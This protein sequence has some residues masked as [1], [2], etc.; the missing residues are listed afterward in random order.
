MSASAMTMP[1]TLNI[2]GDSAGTKK[3]PSEFSMPISTAAT[4]TSVRNGKHDAREVDRQLDLA[5]HRA[6]LRR[7]QAH[8][9][10]GEDDA[11]ER[12]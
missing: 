4:A 12:R 9:R 3:W 5:G 10:V 2:A 8:Q 1:A 6:E 11:D 7:E